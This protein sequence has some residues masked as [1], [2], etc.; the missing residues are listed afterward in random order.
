MK[1]VDLNSD[2]GEG[3]GTYKIGNDEEI[4]KSITSANIACGFHAGDPLIMRK[5][6]K[7]A[8]EHGVAI[9]AHPGFPDLAGFGRRKIEVTVE[10]VGDYVIY[11]IGALAA[12]VRALGGNIQHVKPHG[13]LYNMACQDYKLAFAI[14]RAVYEVDKDLILVGLSGSQIL[15]AGRDLGLKVAS[16]AFADRA[17]THNGQLLSRRTESAVIDD[18]D[19]TVKRALEMVEKGTITT[20]D[21]SKIEVEVDTICVHSDT[22]KSVEIT[23]SL[24]KALIERGIKVEKMGNI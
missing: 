3:F 23:K 9:G 10:E 14:A 19:E 2:L 17:Y 8:I 7:L 18:I 21:G 15:K 1:K 11:Q 24:R 20:V 13:A 6:V 4:M 5:S 12:F 16:E 22:S